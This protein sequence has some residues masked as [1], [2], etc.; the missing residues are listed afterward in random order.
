MIKDNSQCTIKSDKFQC[1]SSSSYYLLFYA[2]VEGIQNNYDAIEIKVK[3]GNTTTHSF[4]QM[5]KVN[6]N[7]WI[8]FVKDYNPGEL[9]GELSIQFDISVPAKA[10]LYLDSINFI[11]HRFTQHLIF[12]F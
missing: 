5:T 2:Y 12:L 8:S 11:K 1:F 10:K 9:S 3:V 7:H 6:N 4:Y